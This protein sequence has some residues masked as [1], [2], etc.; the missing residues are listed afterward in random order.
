M[1]SDESVNGSEVM[2]MS[3]IHR[4]IEFSEQFI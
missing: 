3:Q 4:V 1:V 2:K